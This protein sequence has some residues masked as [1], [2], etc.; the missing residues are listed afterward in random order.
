MA[1][2]TNVLELSRTSGVKL[3]SQSGNSKGSGAFIIIATSMC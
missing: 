3:V 2:G 1:Q